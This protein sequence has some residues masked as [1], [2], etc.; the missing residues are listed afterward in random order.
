[1]PRR[2]RFIPPEGSVVEVTTRTIQ[3][4]LLLR[5][6]PQLNSLILGVLGRAQRVYGVKI[7]DFIFMSNHYHLLLSVRSALQ[8]ARF[9]GY[10][11]GNLAKEVARLTGWKD[12]VWSRRYQAVLVSQEERAQIGRLRYILAHGAKENLVASPREWPG[13]SS[14]KAQLGEDTLEGIWVDRTKEFVA[15]RRGVELSFDELVEA[16][17]VHLSPLPCLQN[18]PGSKREALIAQLLREIE[19][20]TLERGVQTGTKPLGAASVLRQRPADKPRQSKHSPAPFAHCASKTERRLLWQAY[21][22]FL[23]AYLD[24]S[25]TLRAAGTASFPEGAFPPPSPFVDPLFEPG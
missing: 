24:A 4:R 10:L 2:L 23:G 25:E 7:H 19:S 16:E 11:N 18:L 1:M 12:K 22:W 20:E 6:S 8:L 5:P 13:V 21:G 14:L 15:R 17:R 9:M 3:G